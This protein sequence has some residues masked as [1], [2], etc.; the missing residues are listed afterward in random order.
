[1]RYFVVYQ[2]QEGGQYEYEVRDKRTALMEVVA[3]RLAG[4]YADWESR[5]ADLD[6]MYESLDDTPSDDLEG[7]QQEIKIERVDNLPD[8]Q[9]IRVTILDGSTLY[10]FDSGYTEDQHIPVSRKYKKSTA[11]FKNGRHYLPWTVAEELG[12]S[13]MGDSW[14]ESATPAEAL[15]KLQHLK[16]EYLED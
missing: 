1:M 8:F 11:I 5:F 15:R 7:E 6:E 3:H 9:G 10:T 4:D 13:G 12:N 16:R 14:I 2:P